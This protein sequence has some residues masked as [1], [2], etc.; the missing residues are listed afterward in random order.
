MT[1]QVS[2]GY[3]RRIAGAR[4]AAGFSQIELARRLGWPATSNARISGYENED[5]EPSLA[6]FERIAEACGVDPAWLAFAARPMR[7]RKRESQVV[8]S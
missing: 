2:A 7:R 4:R 8:A 1:T 3:G 6:D 5:R